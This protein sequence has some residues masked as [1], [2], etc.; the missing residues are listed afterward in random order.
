MLGEQQ[1]GRVMLRRKCPICI[2]PRGIVSAML[3]RMTK[4]RPGKIVEIEDGRDTHCEQH[5]ENSLEPFFCA[6][7]A[8]ASD[9]SSRR[10][11]AGMGTNAEMRSAIARRNLSSMDNENASA[12]VKG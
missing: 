10:S 4:C 9:R 7:A 6:R 2:N 11:A 1:A 12:P 8:Q 5:R 3:P